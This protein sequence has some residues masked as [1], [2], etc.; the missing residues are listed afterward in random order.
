MTPRRKQSQRGRTGAIAGLVVI[1]VVIGVIVAL[2]HHNT[3]SAPLSPVASKQVVVAAFRPGV[4]ATELSTLS[5]QYLSFAGV[6]AT[7]VIGSQTL[8]IFM[9]LKANSEQVEAVSSA[10]RTQPSVAHVQIKR[11]GNCQKACLRAH[12]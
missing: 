8:E 4:S 9:G 12:S 5:N 2:T 7:E 10:L 11:A 3:P 1:G 6:A